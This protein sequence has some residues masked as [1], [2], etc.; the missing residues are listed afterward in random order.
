[1]KGHAKTEHIERSNKSGGGG[2]ERERVKT[3][4]QQLNSRGCKPIFFSFISR[5]V[6][7]S[8]AEE[9][10]NGRASG[11]VDAELQ[12]ACG[13]KLNGLGTSTKSTK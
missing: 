7:S 1:M 8:S 12:G 6:F 5:F 10:C 9:D 11:E 2:R 4:G 3:N 13:G